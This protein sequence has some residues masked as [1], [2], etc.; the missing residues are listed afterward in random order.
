MAETLLSLP[1]IVFLDVT[2][3]Q[4]LKTNGKGFWPAQTRTV[5]RSRDQKVIFTSCLDECNIF[6][7]PKVLGVGAA[8]VKSFDIYPD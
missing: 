2:S 4:F 7:Q 3:L 6:S 8:R 5:V 1:I